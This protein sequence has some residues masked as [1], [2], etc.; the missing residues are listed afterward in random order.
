VDQTFRLAA[1]IAQQRASG[2]PWLEFH[3]VPDL[4]LGIYTLPAGARDPQQPHAEDEVY[5]VV[6]GRAKLRVGDGDRLAE[7]G[8]ILFVGAGVEHRFHSIEEDLTALVVFGPAEGSRT[9]TR[10]AGGR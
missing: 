7:P 6:S 2:K 10:A 4:S 9:T 1:V 8:A 5:Y 3:R